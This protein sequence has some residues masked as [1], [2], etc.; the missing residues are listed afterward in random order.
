[1]AIARGAKPRVNGRKVYSQTANAIRKR[2]ELNLG[3]FAPDAAAADTSQLTPAPVDPSPEF[4]S[5]PGE[6]S[7]ETIG[8]VTTVTVPDIP[9]PSAE[10]DAPN[11]YCENCKGPVSVTDT[12]CVT[13]E[14][15]L[16]WDGLR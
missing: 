10:D 5:S 15:S 11:Y 1:M 14:E 7:T 16:N 13:C 2:K 12:Q 4:F 9:D 3:E 6:V 8:V